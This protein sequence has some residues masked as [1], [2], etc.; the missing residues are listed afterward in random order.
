MAMFMLRRIASLALVVWIII[1]ITFLM[2]NN[3]KGGPLDGERQ[4]SPEVMEN[5]RQ[6]YNLDASLWER[7]WTYLGN[8][9]RFDFGPSYVYR[10]MTVNEI[11]Q[12][13]WSASALLGL[14]S[15]AI[16][17]LVGV[18]IGVISALRQ[19]RF[20]DHLSMF[21]AILCVSVPN[22]VLAAVLIHVFVNKLNWIQLGWGGPQHVILP[23]LALSAFSLAYITR[24]TRASM[25]ETLRSDYIRTARA[26]GLS[27]GQA[28]TRHAL[29]NALLPVVTYLGPLLAAVTMGSFVVEKFFGIPG[30]GRYFVLGI[31]NR[32]HGVVLALAI[33]YSTLLVSMNTIVDILYAYIDPRIDLKR[34]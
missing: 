26:K 21:G 24:M 6:K 9:A 20:I 17:L 22:F 3:V 13:N 23:A 2:L 28:V 15:V 29:R 11:I 12:D 4:F 31:E 27:M 8:V 5:L 33:L 25:L 32:D 10:D 14:L 7:Y 16:S 30:L 18:P 1:T 34:S 19:N